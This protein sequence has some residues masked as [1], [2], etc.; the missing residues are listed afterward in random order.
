[1]LCLNTS[2]AALREEMLQSLVF[3]SYDHARTVT[4]V[5]T[6]YKALTPGQTGAKVPW[7]VLDHP[8]ANT[9]EMLSVPVHESTFA[10]VLGL[11]R[12]WTNR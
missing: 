1:M 11:F 7:R 10:I 12:P 6:G 8:H 5:V 3:E 9:S 4:W 2:L